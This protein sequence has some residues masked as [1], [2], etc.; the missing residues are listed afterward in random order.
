M[1]LVPLLL[2]TIVS[3]A[4]A[5]DGR[6]IIDTKFDN[7]AAFS[8]SAIPT[9]DS[10]LPL[11]S[12][13]KIGVMA[14]SLFQVGEESVG[15]IK[16]PYA[17]AKVA[18]REEVPDITANMQIQWALQKLPLAPG[19]YQFS[20]QLGMIEAVN[21]AGSFA[22]S[23]VGADGQELK[24]RN[25]PRVFFFDGK[26]RS[27]GSASVP[28]EPGTRYSILI[29]VDTEHFTWSSSVNGEPLQAEDTSFEKDLPTGSAPAC[30]F[31]VLSYSALSGSDYSR[32][33]SSLGIFEV[34]M[35]PFK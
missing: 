27:G 33:G 5:E 35:I 31:G 26:I 12:P 25:P 3:T 6:A 32:P 18:G 4:C 21:D 11:K 1:K 14:P 29:I 28:F 34:K 8:K 10:D 22:V 7:A 2:A 30:R 13:T 19:R 24:L 15:D 9:R 16:P 23:L 17:L 20:I